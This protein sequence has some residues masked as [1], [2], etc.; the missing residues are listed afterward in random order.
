[1]G[2]QDDV[3]IDNAKA[4]TVVRDEGERMVDPNAW[5]QQAVHYQIGD[6]GAEALR[7]VRMT[8]T[9]EREL[10]LSSRALNRRE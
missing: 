4:G 9:H 7:D 3:W 6:I 5:A 8:P 1:M 10:T 2:V